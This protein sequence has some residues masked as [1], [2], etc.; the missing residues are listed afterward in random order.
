[1]QMQ[2]CVSF[3]AITTVS[4]TQTQPTKTHSKYL[5][6]KMQLLLMSVENTKASFCIQYISTW[7]NMD[8]ASYVWDC[9]NSVGLCG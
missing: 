3:I 8:S 4:D 1:M 9:G 6:S 5:E 2:M 7:L